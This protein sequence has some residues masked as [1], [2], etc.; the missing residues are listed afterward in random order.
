MRC[1][2]YWFQ[3]VNT[4]K[5]V[6]RS[7]LLAQSQTQELHKYIFSWSFSLI[8]VSDH[9]AN[10]CTWARKRG[11][12][13]SF[14]WY[15][16]RWNAECKSTVNQKQQLNWIS[17]KFQEY[18]RC[19]LWNCKWLETFGCESHQM[20]CNVWNTYVEKSLFKLTTKSIRLIE[21]KAKEMWRRAKQQQQ[22]KI[23]A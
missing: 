23:C 12:K 8:F 9:D 20:Q 19:P 17:E 6:R 21:F 5:H 4:T 18:F 3:R 22:R 10:G 15:I 13:H 11:K 16:C 14:T 2:I 1:A 7:R